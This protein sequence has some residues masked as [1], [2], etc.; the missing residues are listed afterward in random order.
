M[1]CAS[2]LGD[3]AASFPRHPVHGRRVQRQLARAGRKHNHRQPLLRGERYLPE[4]FELSTVSR[5]IYGAK[6]V[7]IEESKTCCDR[8]IHCPTFLFGISV[9]YFYLEVH[10]CEF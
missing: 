2:I 1:F 10:R 3:A 4:G 5:K 6:Y 9:S 8:V 7:K